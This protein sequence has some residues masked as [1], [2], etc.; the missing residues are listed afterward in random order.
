MTRDAQNDYATYDFRGRTLVITFRR[1]VVID[2][3]VAGVIN[4]QRLALTAVRNA[5]VLY[6]IRA[7]SHSEK[8]G[9]DYFAAFGCL[10]T[11]AAALFVCSGASEVTAR[12]FLHK[13]RFTI[14]VQVFT[15]EVSA[16]SFLATYQ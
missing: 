1:G 13:H 14:P 4:A 12:F 8:S 16:L 9:R 5:A 15:D 7:I 2:A 3:A 11:L 6:D 10:G